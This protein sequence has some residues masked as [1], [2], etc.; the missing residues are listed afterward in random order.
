MRVIQ[1]AEAKPHFSN[2]SEGT[3][4]YEELGGKL[5]SS[6]KY[7]SLG[8]DKANIK[9]TNL[10]LSVCFQLR[11]K[12]IFQVSPLDSNLAHWEIA[13]DVCP[14][15]HTAQLWDLFLASC[16]FACNCFEAVPRQPFTQIHP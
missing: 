16:R 12:C 10:Q 15:A 4:S 14:Q 6:Y 1:T 5:I 7:T 13:K 3:H 8:T 9:Q 11:R 2:D